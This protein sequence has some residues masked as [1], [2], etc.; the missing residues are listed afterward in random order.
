MLLG[1]IVRNGRNSLVRRI[2][3]DCMHMQYVLVSAPMGV[4][5][6]S[7]LIKIIV[8]ASLYRAI[9]VKDVQFE[10]EAVRHAMLSSGAIGV[11]RS[12]CSALS[13]LR[14]M[15]IRRVFAC[16]H[17]V[18]LGRENQTFQNVQKVNGKF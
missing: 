16:S 11:P 4:E 3:C 17:A 14:C 8:S 10:R 15:R 1:S 18:L 9:G 5:L 6:V 12:A 7:Y 13:R 2:C